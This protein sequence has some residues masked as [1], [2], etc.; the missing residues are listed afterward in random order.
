MALAVG[1][2]CAAVVLLLLAAPIDV[3][4]AVD[5]DQALRAR[6]HVSWLFGLVRFRVRPEG[7]RPGMKAKRPASRRG[8]HGKRIARRVAGGMLRPDFRARS[9]A[10]LRG[11]L[12]AIRP[13][14][15]RVRGRIGLGDPADTGRMWGVLGTL[16]VLLS[17]HDVRLEPDF[18]QACLRF[19]AAGR[20]RLIPIQMLFMTTAFL[21]SPA[22]VR[23]L[24][25]G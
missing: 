10:F 11:L 1:F 12:R 15:V 13:R 4:V 3:R 5:R 20:M 6:V 19:Q 24:A 17:Q 16:G 9:F 22:V 18:E 2:A 23:T 14:D 7:T 8:R 25:L 21:V